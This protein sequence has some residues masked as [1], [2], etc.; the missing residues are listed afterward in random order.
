MLTHRM[1]PM[2]A[3]ATALAIASGVIGLYASFHFELAA[4]ASIAGA[5]V[6]ICVA[7]LA[8]SPLLTKPE[9]R[10]SPVPNIAPS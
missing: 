7:A 9:Q 3:L 5:T 2:M 10:P 6:L 4:G 8:A 1:A